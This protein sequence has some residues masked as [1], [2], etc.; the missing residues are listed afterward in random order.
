MDGYQRLSGP[1]DQEQEPAKKQAARRANSDIEG[2]VSWICL[3]L[4]VIII[5]VT[6]NWLF[7]SSGG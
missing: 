1:D 4:E 5:N 2:I 3:N 6:G 7:H